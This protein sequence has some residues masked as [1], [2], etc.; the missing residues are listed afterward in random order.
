MD[1]PVG[2]A[3]WHLLLLL[4]TLQQQLAPIGSAWLPRRIRVLLL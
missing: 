2:C 3:V 4:K 1:S